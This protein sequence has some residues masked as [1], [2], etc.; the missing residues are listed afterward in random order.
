MA[1]NMDSETISKIEMLNTGELLL[2][3][4]SQGKPTYQYVY[5]EAAGVYWDESRR[6]FKSTP[7]K[8]WS[9]S[10]WFLHIVGVVQTGLGVKLRLG[11]SVTWRNIPDQEKV[12]IERANTI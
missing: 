8:E 3:I 11:K 2:G 9:C 12:E 5:R 7:I 1:A 10:K 4:V 6:G